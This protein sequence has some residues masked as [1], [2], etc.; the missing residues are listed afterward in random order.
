[1]RARILFPVIEF[2]I[3]RSAS[4]ET[5]TP[6]PHC[7]ALRC[8]KAAANGG[9]S[10]IYLESNSVD[11]AYNLALEQYAF[12]ALSQNDDVFMLWQNSDSVIVGLHQNTIEEINRGFVEK[13][14]IHVVRRLSGGGAV[15]HDLGN[16]NYT[17]I[18]HI[19]DASSIDFAGSCKPIADALISMGLPVEFS[20]RNDMTIDGKKFSGNAR[21]YRDGRLMHHGTLLFDTDLDKMSQALL[22][23]VDKLV[24]KSVKSV[25]SRVINLCDYLDATIDEFWASVRKSVAGDIPA[26]TLSV[27]DRRAVE[28]IK[29]DRYDT[30]EWNYGKSPEFSVEKRRRIEKFGAIRLR[31]SAAGGKITGFATDG[32]YFG[33]KTCDD[34]AAA[35]LGVE[36]ESSALLSALNSVDLSNYYEGL[37]V[38]EFV[39]L[40]LE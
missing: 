34:V 36:L 28:S 2:S 1:L 17:F 25:R 27:Q 20:G 8:V 29:R 9:T 31:M 38:E 13:N 23:P 16:L 40:I 14:A 11:P 35:L 7:V 19:E 4:G 22:V 21:Y 15:F 10:M 39:R 37:Y 32:D 24:S 3:A 18:T 33:V 6:A 30:W 5:T 12:D 26:H